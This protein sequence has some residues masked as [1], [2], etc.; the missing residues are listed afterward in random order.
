MK[1][2]RLEAWVLSVVDQVIAG[3]RVEDSRLELKAD[4]PDPKVAARR[5]AGHA[6]AAGSDSILWILGLSE[7]VG[8]SRLSSV[9]VADWMPAVLAMPRIASTAWA[10]RCRI[11]AR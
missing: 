6:N 10:I 9:D 1:S 8:I 3:R 7:E 11:P 5:I 4:W 2:E